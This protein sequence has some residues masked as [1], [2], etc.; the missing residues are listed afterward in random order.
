MN[1]LITGGAGYLG[2][3]LVGKLLAAK[4]QK[5]ST[6]GALPDSSAHDTQAHQIDFNKV[7]VYDNLMYR[8]VCLTDYAYREDFTFVHGDV[9]NHT[10]LRKYVQEADVIVPLAA[11]VG[12]PACDKDPRLA[13]EVNFEHVEFIHSITSSSQKI[14]YPNTNSG[15]G[16]GRGEEF[17]TENSTLSPISHYG[18]TK[19]DAENLLLNG[20]RAVTLRLATVF[21]VSPRMRLD[22]LVNDF[23][24]KAVNDGY[25]V[26]FEKDFKRNF[27]YIRDVALTFIYLIN[28]YDEF[29]G[30]TF[31]VG[32]SDANLTKLELA[33]K[34]KEHVPAFSIQWDDFATDPDK[35][36]YVVSNAKLE[37]TGWRPYYSLDDGIRELISAYRIIQHNNRNFTNL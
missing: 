14:L 5:T 25:I 12:Y 11:I 7:V 10:L 18:R 3:V 33:R 8:Q 19:C 35:R 23:T 21:G 20:G 13:T 24:Y 9:R 32:L 29:V 22:L 17:C 37:A 31:N 16:L 34:I 27:I 36:D 30:Q 2:S 26:L 6:L 15:Y 4:T 1:I 28:R